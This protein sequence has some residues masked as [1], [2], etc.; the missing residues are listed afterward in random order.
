MKLSLRARAIAPIASL[1]SFVA[2][3]AATYDEPAGT[4][5]S[6]LT[7]GAYDAPRGAAIAQRAL[8]MWSG[9]SSRNLCLAGVNDTLERSGVVSPAFPRL[10]SAVAFD[11]WARANPGELARRGF[12]RETLSL[13]AIPRGTIIT[14][15]PGQCGYHARYG[16]VEIVV[17]D[18]SSRACSDY[19]GAIRK[20]CGA[21]GMYVPVRSGGGGASSCSVAADKK[22]YCGNKPNVALHERPTAGSP[23]VNTLRS[24]H[25]WFECW[26]PGQMHSGGNTTWYW[27]LGDD[28]RARGF[29]P[30][31]ALETSAEL[32]Q[33]PTAAGLVRCGD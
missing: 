26:F 28:N 2:C 8:S 32:D 9:R 1:A 30:A 10:P 22:L 27:T 19:C 4:T 24:T 25:S 6:D 15:R 23:V 16:H 31:S 11:D 5:T 18:A 20:N 33:N 7:H 21:P 3:T 14:W 13:D 17:D 12:A 29:V